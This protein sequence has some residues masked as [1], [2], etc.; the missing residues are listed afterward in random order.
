VVTGAE[1]ELLE[2]E[3]DVAALE[4]ALKRSRSGDGGV[5]AVSGVAG[6]GKTRLIDELC[7][8]ARAAGATVLT[9]R[10]S[11]VERELG[12]GVVRQL[13]ER[14]L[15]TAGEDRRSELLAGAAA[16][17]APTLDV[18]V[19]STP[20]SIDPAFAPLHG[21]YWLTVNLATERPLVLA[22]DDGHWA[23][24]QSLRCLEYLGRR[25]E[26]LPV[27]LAVAA[28]SDDP[29]AKLPLLDQPSTRLIE[30][31]LLS[32]DAAKACIRAVLGAEPSVRFAAACHSATGGNPFLLS[33]LLK[34]LAADGIAPGDEQAGWVAE[35]APASVARSVLA[36]LAQLGPAANEVVRAVAV[37]GEPS[38]LVYA[39]AVAELQP[40]EAIAA[41]DALVRADVLRR[42]DGLDFVHPIVRAA[43]YADMT[44]ADRTEGHARAARVLADDGARAEKIA[45]QLVLTEPPGDPWFV[46][47]LQ[48]AARDALAHGSPESAASFFGR[49]LREPSST[50][51]RRELLWN[52]GR[53]QGQMGDSRSAIR[54]IDSAIEL[55]DDR[56]DRAQARRELA[57]LQ[58]GRGDAPRAVE[59]LDGAIGELT[60]ADADLGIDL[61]ADLARAGQITLEARRLIRA[62]APRFEPSPDPLPPLIL[63]HRAMETVMRGRASDAAAD[64]RRAIDGG[65]LV[66]QTSDSPSFY[67]AVNAFLFSGETEDALAVYDEALADARAR[68][69]ARGFS[70]ASCCRAIAQ[71]AYGDVTAAEA[72]ARAALEVNPAG[73]GVAVPVAIAYLVMSLVERGEAKSAEDVIA[74]Y[75]IPEPLAATPFFSHY[76]VAKARLALVGRDDDAA[77]ELLFECGRREDAWEIGTPALTQWR[78]LLAPVLAVLGRRNEARTLISEELQRCRSFG[79]SRHLGVSLRAAALVEEGEQRTAMLREAIGVLER[80]PARLE[81]ARALVDLGT[82]LRHGRDRTDAR[83]PLD[84]A[85]R[86][87]RTCGAT[88]L[89]E[90]AYAELRAAGARPRKIV[91]G[92][93]DALTPSELRVCRMAADGMTNKEIAQA[94]FVTMR[95]VETHLT[96]AYQKL[97][98]SSRDAIAAALGDH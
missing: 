30:P 73:L 74:R 11:E 57:W 45:S 52:L 25:L 47:T 21:T 43:V 22:I 94:L 50:N 4:E 96:H 69:S 8:R 75:P 97:A 66:A 71:Y 51:T 60:D 19:R 41:V 87:A 63:A 46:P 39:A 3:A 95:T 49:A 80:S 24:P 7:V 9:A 53:A 59:L 84:E 90:H 54:T 77:V 64:A 89:A 20:A 92:G 35:L 65:L 91:R 55:M 98:I 17:V 67:M 40:S 58:I 13:F 38:H 31:R 68:G 78:A 23:D 15:V 83:A 82:T 48:A 33:E 5:V 79:S 34:M 14:L 18:P 81:R 37:L 26:G 10:G 61:E 56:R 27:L 29:S 93:A 88:A 36:R 44:L 32:E 62:R 72:D 2:R 16:L 70:L 86:V 6:I 1:F 76:L 42:K 85:L 28:R 12:F